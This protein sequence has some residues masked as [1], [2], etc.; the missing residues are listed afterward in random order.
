MAFA[1][2]S[3]LQVDADLTAD[4]GVQA[5]IDVCTPR[6]KTEGIQLVSDMFTLIKSAECFNLG[7]QTIH[8]ALLQNY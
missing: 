7:N 2:V 6:E 4:A 3:A 1:L 5:L 8:M